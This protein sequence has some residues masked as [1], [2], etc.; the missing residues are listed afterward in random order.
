[1]TKLPHYFARCVL[2]KDDAERLEAGTHRIDRMVERDDKRMQIVVSPVLPPV[3]S[4]LR[5]D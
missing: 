2:D 1:M 3:N 5:G 4:N